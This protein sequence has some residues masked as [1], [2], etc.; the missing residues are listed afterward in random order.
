MYRSLVFLAMFISSAVSGQIKNS[1]DSIIAQM[2]VAAKELLIDKSYP[3]N[4]DTLYG[5]YLSSFT[6]DFK[7][8]GDQDKMI[9]TQA[10]HIWS[11]SKAAQ[12][13]HDT[14]YI[15][16]ARHGFNFL[17]DKM[18]DKEHGGFYNLVNRKGEPKSLTKE[19]YG[20]SFAIYA[21]AA[22]FAASGD[23]AALGLAKQTFMW[24]EQ[25]S[26]DPKFKGYFQHLERNG[27]PI[28][29]P[30]ST[31]ATSDLGYK[32]QNSSIHL[33][34]S[35]TELYSVWKDSLLKE[36]L[37]EMLLLIRDTMIGNKG[38]LTLFFYP[39]WKPVSNRDVSREIIL[40]RSNVDHVSFGHDVETAYL[41]M[42]ASE[43]L[44]I[45]HD[46]KTWAVGKQL[47][48]HSLKNGWD[49]KLG[50]FYDEGYY[51]K[52]SP[53]KMTIIRN[54]KNW[55]AQSEGLNTLLIFSD[56]YPHD[57]MNYE[58]KFRKLWNYTNTYLID[59]EYGDFYEFGLDNSPKS[60]TALKAHIWKGTYHSF[61]ALSNC[62]KRMEKS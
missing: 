55:W 14:S 17:R 43:A 49:N 10:R 57:K 35:F 11:T 56:L 50:G 20:N 30:A 18:W 48:D 54:T 42:E 28:V 5:G 40:E 32:D 12:F 36:R 24:L 21:L 27:K 25:H 58:E 15:S 22:Y 2:K 9:V 62:I 1:R 45:E 38:Y 7:P 4:L 33:L 3:N 52:D 37:N 13:Y 44:G 46:K 53:R 47:V 29:R 34:E 16:M 19:A 8:Y 23:T 39:D 31:P 51:F 60:R 26:H 61:R 6:Y 59:H 41:M